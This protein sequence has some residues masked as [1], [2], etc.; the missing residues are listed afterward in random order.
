[1][2]RGKACTEIP[3]SAAELLVATAA[4]EELHRAS[5]D[6]GIERRKETCKVQ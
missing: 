6:V 5:A 2:T 4:L 3:S 1:M